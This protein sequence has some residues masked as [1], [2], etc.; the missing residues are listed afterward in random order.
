M[1]NFLQENDLMKIHIISYCFFVWQ[2]N[3]ERK[4]KASE[5][6][7]YLFQVKKALSNED[8]DLPPP[9]TKRPRATCSTSDDA[10]TRDSGNQWSWS[11]HI[12][13]L[14]VY[15]EQ[16]PI[17]DRI[18]G[19]TIEKTLVCNFVW[20]NLG[21]SKPTKS[22][23]EMSWLLWHCTHKTLKIFFVK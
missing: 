21:N 8:N 9:P 3:L 19:F 18:L 12:G 6:Y 10:D 23:Y 16:S 14:F 4:K 17:S 15:L 7:I 2:T 20:L 13:E 11:Q 22:W 1:I 5:S